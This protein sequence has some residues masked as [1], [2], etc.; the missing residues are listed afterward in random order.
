MIKH[1][2]ETNKKMLKKECI[3]IVNEYLEKKYFT[4]KKKIK[5]KE[6]DFF[7]YG[8]NMKIHFERLFKNTNLDLILIENQIGPLALRMKVL[9]GMI[10]QHFIERNCKN[11]LSVNSSNKLKEFIQKK[12]TYNERKKESINITLKLLENINKQFLKEK[13]TSFFNKKTNKNVVDNNKPNTNW[14]EY[15]K[16]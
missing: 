3:K 1:E 7:T 16:T 11:V 9:Q 2:I 15:L 12:T 6:V 14:Y 8:K 13:Q 4:T 10:L 5:T